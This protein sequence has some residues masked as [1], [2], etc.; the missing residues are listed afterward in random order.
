MSIATLVTV[1]EHNFY[2]IVIILFYFIIREKMA[3][4]T[5]VNLNVPVLPSEE[6]MAENVTTVQLLPHRRHMSEPAS[7]Q[8]VSVSKTNVYSVSNNLLPN[9]TNIANAVTSTTIT[10]SFAN[11]T[12]SDSSTKG[13]SAVSATNCA[14]TKINGENQNSIDS[15]VTMTVNL[16]QSSLDK[17]N[18]Q[19]QAVQTEDDD[20]KESDDSESGGGE[21]KRYEYVV[22]RVL[23]VE[24]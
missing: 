16:G 8:S 17:D 7:T 19:C 9:A 5:R 4:F 20:K 6:L 1:V 2:N 10:N 12:N 13:N 22:D 14:T 24:V 3:F 21:P 18:K 23:G 11:K 15:D